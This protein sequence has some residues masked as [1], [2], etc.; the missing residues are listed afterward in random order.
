MSTSGWPI[1]A[2][3]MA[4]P[5]RSTSVSR[6]AMAA[7]NSWCSGK[8]TSPSVYGADQHRR[9]A[10]HPARRPTRSPGVGPGGIVRAMSRVR[11]YQVGE[12][13][14]AVVSDGYLRMDGGAVFGLVPRVL[15]EPVV[16]SE[17]VDDQHRVE[18]ALNCMLVRRGDDV[19][20]VETGMGNKH[21]P[22]AARG[23]P[24]DYGYLLEALAEAGVRPEDVTA[25]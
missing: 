9:P 18:Q 7:A 20:L 15:W 1:R 13:D 8:S 5:Y 4:P 24:G 11:R 14:I 3:A 23:F 10:H 12:F 21:D 19:V 25:V 17:N 2:M 22:R 16:G 6:P